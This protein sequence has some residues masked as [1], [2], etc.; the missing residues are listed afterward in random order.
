MKCHIF[1]ISACILL[2]FVIN[3][4]DVYAQKFILLQ[5]GTNQKS[6]LKFEVGETFTYKS[7]TND[8]YITDVIKDIQT[9]I[10]VLSENILKPEDITSVDI[11]DK[12]PRNGTLKN[13]STLSYGAGLIWLTAESINSLYH[14]KSFGISSGGMIGAGALFASGFTLS[15]IRR[16]HFKNTKRNKIQLVIL[17]GD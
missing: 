3:L 6:R 9:D 13:L 1:K 7:K 12:D 2:L 17:Y 14:D 11:F 8:F 5:K 10:I 15:K 4:N 16:R